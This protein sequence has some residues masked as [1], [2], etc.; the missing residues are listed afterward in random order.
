LKTH[1]YTLPSSPAAIK[2][3]SSDVLAVSMAAAALPPGTIHSP[4]NGDSM[5]TFSSSS[6]VVAFFAPFFPL[7]FGDPFPLPFFPPSADL[8][9]VFGAAAAAEAAAASCRSV[10]L[11]LSYQRIEPSL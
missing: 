3:E 2:T 6:F 4:S 10:S 7:P 8:E 11:L 5:G 9:G 1:T